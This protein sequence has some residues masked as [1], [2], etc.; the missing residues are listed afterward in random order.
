M[1]KHLN[2]N[3]QSPK[4]LKGFVQSRNTLVRYASDVKNRKGEKYTHVRKNIEETQETKPQCEQKK[5][6]THQN[7][8]T[9]RRREKRFMQ[10]KQKPK[11]RSK[12]QLIF[13]LW[14]PLK[15]HY[16]NNTNNNKS[17]QFIIS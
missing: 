13:F 12:N 6:R 14:I 15:T 9:P 3:M 8:S 5:S 7:K 11:T 17:H 1:V 2:P 4:I 10:N 16:N